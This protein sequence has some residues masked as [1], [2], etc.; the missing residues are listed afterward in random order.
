MVDVVEAT[1][2]NRGFLHIGIPMMQKLHQHN[3]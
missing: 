1:L 2:A 3:T